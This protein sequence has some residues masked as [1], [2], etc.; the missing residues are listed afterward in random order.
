MQTPSPSPFPTYDPLASQFMT[1]GQMGYMPQA[2]YLTSSD[3]GAFRTMPQ[4]GV[5]MPVQPQATLWQDY[6]TAN[7]GGPF[8]LPDY[9]VNTYNPSVNQLRHITMARRRMDDASASF[10]GALFDT[11]A[12]MG[13]GMAAGW[14]AGP[15]AGMAAGLAMPMLGAAV[16]DRRR[17]GRAM[18]NMSMSKIMSGPDM[19]RSLSQGFSMP[20][21]MKLDEGIRE[22]AAS[23]VLF[24]E[25]DYRKIL[26]LGMQAGMYDY[27]N[28]I[29][30]YKEITKR[31]R[32]NFKA[33]A[34]LME[35]MDFGEIAAQ[36]Q[37]LQRM[38]AS[39]G[40][41]TSIMNKEAMYKRMLGISHQDMVS[42]YGQQG[43]MIFSQ[44]GL[45]NYHGSSLNMANAAMIETK[46][47][48]GLLTPAEIARQGGESGMAQDMTNA[49]GTL[50]KET[51]WSYLPF[52]ANS[53]F[54]DIDRD[55]IL[56]LATGDIS[57]SEARL[58]A[59]KAAT[60]QR[61]MAKYMANAPDLEDKVMDILG[62][63]LFELFQINK[64]KDLV[65]LSGGDKNNK[66]DLLAAL[67]KLVGDPKIAKQM[68]ETG[69]NPEL[70]Q[71]KLAQAEQQKRN[72]EFEAREERKQER[73]IWKSLRREFKEFYYD[74]VESPISSV[75][76][77]RAERDE[78][79]ENKRLGILTTTSYGIQG[80]GTANLSDAEFAKFA[81]G[82][83][84]KD[85]QDVDYLAKTSGPPSVAGALLTYFG[86]KKEGYAQKKNALAE[87]IY[88]AK[89]LD[90]EFGR[91]LALRGIE[92]L[93]FSSSDINKLSRMVDSQADLSDEGIRRLAAKLG[94]DD[95]KINS[96]MGSEDARNLLYNKVQKTNKKVGEEVFDSLGE[97]N[98]SQR[99]K[100]FEELQELDKGLD[101]SMSD[102]VGKKFFMF[103]KDGLVD[104]LKSIGDKDLRGLE[105]LGIAAMLRGREDLD[106]QGKAEIDK[107]LAARLKA[108]GYKEGEIDRIIRGDSEDFLE[109]AAS[110]RGW[111]S[112]TLNGATKIAEEA[113]AGKSVAELEQGADAAG[114]MARKYAEKEVE[115]KYADLEKTTRGLLGEH[116]YDAGLS[117][118]RALNDPSILASLAK[119]ADSP[120]ER[121]MYAKLLEAKQ[122]NP[123]KEIT[124]L[125]AVTLLRNNLSNSLTES[126][127]GVHERM[128]TKEDQKA[129][130]QL[131]DVI[132]VLNDTLLKMNANLAGGNRMAAAATPGIDAPA[133]R[134]GSTLLGN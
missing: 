124:K 12:P 59:G 44:L 9:L 5:H 118:E 84:D 49:L 27:S 132:K 66:D 40:Q 32:G 90:K 11:L 123:E 24:K 2:Q 4:T 104:T 94:W 34:G 30:Q 114:R 65:E 6:L 131:T 128:N 102:F 88:A 22:S 31:L 76:R 103:K 127:D 79:E 48:L 89:D 93:G 99:A 72:M 17:H 100:T 86:D 122:A 53:D 80:G 16:A 58:H 47:R 110:K 85:S 134:R 105:D 46:K 126:R 38:G 43:A 74:T 45:T 56:G 41:H 82:S 117:M 115:V 120:R 60:N 42:T 70:L 57:F 113:G 29:Q 87:K 83:A 129:Y 37:R 19:S 3:Y 54:T 25:E 77:A 119:Y 121:A 1:G 33:F 116:G 36:M 78:R 106:E 112:E 10:G 96:F 108:A 35:T 50:Q 51:Q 23:D 97:F 39:S 71:A 8:G 21:A 20:A 15:M 130:N 26:E 133:S 68:A 67:M 62:P 69:T 18:Q 107:S 109:I 98:F 63:E 101:D 61:D 55:K 91:D 7:R 92:S 81:G 52:A 95:K 73:G 75:A 14:A 111:D 28:N 13:V 64:A 125:D